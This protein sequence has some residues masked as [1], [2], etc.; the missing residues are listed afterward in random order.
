M[1]KT[2]PKTTFL[3]TEFLKEN[4]V[5]GLSEKVLANLKARHTSE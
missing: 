4:I 5:R 2:K 1:A 3:L